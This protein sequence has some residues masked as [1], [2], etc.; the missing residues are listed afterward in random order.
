MCTGSVEDGELVSRVQRVQ[1]RI[2][3]ELT[4]KTLIENTDGRLKPTVNTRHLWPTHGQHHHH[5]SA[6][7]LLI[8]T[9]RRSCGAFMFTQAHDGQDTD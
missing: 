4:N 1:R 2:H 5:R 6:V 7:T 9:E 3:T 8:V